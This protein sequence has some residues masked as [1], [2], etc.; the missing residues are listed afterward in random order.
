M[1]VPMAAATSPESSMPH[2][3]PIGFRPL[4]LILVSLGG[5]SCRAESAREANAQ[6]GVMGH[7]RVAELFFTTGLDGYIEPCGCTTK[8]LG[9]LPRLATVV[10]AA[11]GDHALVDAGQLLLPSKGYD[12][13]TRPQHRAK[14]KLLARAFRKLGAVAMNVTPQELGE[15]LSFLAELQQEGAVP[16]VSANV[17]PRGE[18]GPEV[19]RSYTRMVGGIRIGI[20]GLAI[21]ERVAGVSPDVAALEFAPAV[22]AEVRTLRESGAELVVVLAHLPDADARALAVAVPEIDL[23][24]RSPG[25][26]IGRPPS[27]PVQVG[28]VI[29]AE[30]GTQGQY[31]GRARIVLAGG[32]VKRPLVLDDGGAKVAEEKARLERRVAALDKD[33]ARL[34]GQP[35]RKEEAVAKQ[36]VKEQL[37]ARLARPAA[38]A[39]SPAGSHVQVSVVPLDPDVAED[40]EMKKLLLVYY[41]KLRAMNLERGDPAACKLSDEASP[42]YMGTAACVTCHQEAFDFWKTTKHA[43]AWWTLERDAK[44]YDFTCVGCHSVGFREPGGFCILKGSEMYHNVGCESCH[45]PGSRHAQAPTPGTIDRGDTPATCADGCHVPEHSDA[46]VYETY[47]R[48]ILGPGHGEE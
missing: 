14:A 29:L 2:S 4:A 41:Q 47:V 39:P 22:R 33:L 40:D 44:H 13:L 6:P 8:P 43:K 46:F 26:E 27:P 7:H 21:P 35:H 17:R 11:G 12:E 38:K 42:R 25:S 3:S 48:Q 1:T 30:A 23:I 18:G 9:G 15:G 10:G 5:L 37:M 28:P 16:F 32:A 20:T 36:R 34:E 31:V 45:G 19:A 24:L